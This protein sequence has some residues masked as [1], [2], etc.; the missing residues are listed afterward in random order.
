MARLER[1]AVGSRLPD[2]QAVEYARSL[3]GQMGNN[4]HAQEILSYIEQRHEIFCH[5]QS[6]DSAAG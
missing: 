1:I 5:I 2:M 3:V 6:R 4:R